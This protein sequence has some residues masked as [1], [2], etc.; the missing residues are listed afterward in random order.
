MSIRRELGFPENVRLVGIVGRYH[1][2]KDHRNFIKAA[3]KVQ[4]RHPECRFVMV[5]SGMTWNN[6]EL[7]ACLQETGIANVTSL[8]GAREDM[9]R[10]NAALDV[11][12]S[13]SFTEAFPN[14]IGE[15]M[16]CGVPCVVTDVGDSALLVGNTGIVTPPHDP[17][18]LASGINQMLDLSDQNRR[19]LGAAARERVVAEFSL[20]KIA[21][22][23]SSLYLSILDKQSE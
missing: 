15:A 5:G 8:L 2:M 17:E 14:V 22:S 13:S 11:A 23:F 10:V 6:K 21:A 19:A 1:P 9:P 16:S 18:V 20:D 3:A 12:V 4:A 7:A